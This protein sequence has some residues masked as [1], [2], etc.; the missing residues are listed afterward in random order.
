[1]V[2]VKER[3]Y[4]LKKE[5]KMSKVNKYLEL[6][7]KTEEAQQKADKAAGALSQVMKQLKTE[8]DCSTLQ[9]AEKQLKQLQ[10]QE[11]KL[12]QEFDQAI[13]TYEEKWESE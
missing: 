1:M 10:K 3:A 13:E 5:I 9:E 12:T 11:K 2:I 4:I 7:K 6:K 8:F